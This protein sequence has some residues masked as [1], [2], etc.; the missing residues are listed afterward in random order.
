[1]E[2][3]AEGDSP[4]KGNGA[5]RD[6]N[7]P[8]GSLSEDTL[9][10]LEVTSNRSGDAGWGARCGDGVGWLLRGLLRLRAHPEEGYE[11]PGWKDRKWLKSTAS[12]LSG[13]PG[14]LSKD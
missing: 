14:R 12:M 9:L 2:G 1:M 10:P 13:L 5:L 7:V 4:A 6:N 8:N 3:D 11:P